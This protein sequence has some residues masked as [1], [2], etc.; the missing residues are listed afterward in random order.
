MGYLRVPEVHLACS[1]V[2]TFSLIAGVLVYIKQVV[3]NFRMREWQSS[4]HC[5]IILIASLTTL[6]LPPAYAASKP[7]GELVDARPS[8]SDDSLVCSFYLNKN[9]VETVLSKT[10]GKKHLKKLFWTMPLL[11]KSLAS[12][13]LT[14]KKFGKPSSPSS[15][16]KLKKLKAV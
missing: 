12:V 9:K 2:K 7:Y 11:K 4:A 5:L 10:D 6:Y 8:S 1:C 15:I 14:I 13:T 3:G 16:K